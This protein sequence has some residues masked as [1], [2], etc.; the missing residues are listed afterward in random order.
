MAYWIHKAGTSTRPNY[1]FFYMDSDESVSELPTATTDGIKQSVDSSAHNVCSIGSKALSLSTSTIYK[2]DSNNKWV[3]QS[4]SS[5]S[6]SGGG[7]S[8]Y[9]I[10]VE[11]GFEG[12]VEEWLQSLN[13]KDGTDGTDGQTPTI[14]ENG[15]WFLGENDTGK[16][17]RGEKGEKG[18]SGE[19]G[20]AGA[21]GKDGKSA[22]EIAIE[23]GF[24]GT[25]KEWLASLEGMDGF[26][27]I[28]VENESNDDII[29]KLD[30]TTKT[31]TV[32]TPN[33]KGTDGVDGSVTPEQVQDAVEDYFEKNPIESLTPEEK[34][35][36]AS[37]ENKLDKNQG[38]EN[39]GKVLV[40]GGDGTV[41]PGETP[42]KVD[43]TLTQ[44]GQAADA[45]ATGDKLN[46]LSE[47]IGTTFS[48]ILKNNGISVIAEDGYY[49]TKGT[50]NPSATG[51]LF[52][53][54]PIFFVNN[55]P[56]IFV[57]YHSVVT[58]KGNKCNGQTFA[59]NIDSVPDFDK[60]AFNI[61]QDSVP[62]GEKIYLYL[63]YDLE[64]VKN[65]LEDVKN[66]L[67]DVKNNP[68]TTN[69]NSF[70]VGKKANFLGDSIT[71]GLWGGPEDDS[72][73]TIVDKKF[74]EVASE[75][76]GLDSI[77][78]GQ[79]GTCISSALD[80]SSQGAMSKRYKNMRDDADLIVVC[81]GTNDYGTN[82]PLGV[83][84]DTTDVS[85]YGGLKVLCN[86]LTEKY[87][88]KRI[89]FITPIHRGNEGNNSDGHT[90]I[91]YS[92][93][94]Y[95]VARDIFGFEVIDGFTLG[96]SPF[97]DEAKMYY[98]GHLDTLHPGPEGH[99]IYGTCLAHKLNVA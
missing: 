29:Y 19:K 20:P 7:Q 24:K 16:P 85:F 49:N 63:N 64:D 96:L 69:V 38:A 12:T 91:E 72:P 10:A 2:L 62:V 30:I 73:S 37:I 47:D 31:G 39:S 52:V 27:P 45:K 3:A 59:Q 9:Q 1:R 75:I 28:I 22:Y 33:L 65:D 98:F 17:S 40:V 90:L 76:L 94:I 46:S 78:Y 99:K 82:V 11:Y 34:E 88:G 41:T 79:S 74:W 21:N 14:G 87:L 23:N 93:A 25:E 35:Q 60:I 70:W 61:P 54:T 97:N 57:Q 77:G 13:G 44:S 83:I 95:D 68:P 80:P 56:K 86:G 4:S 5:G 48:G 58:W 43:P 26:S 66:D 36:I 89:V 50:I 84:G 18:D 8:A 6:S 15:N 42:I 55:V 71:V 51:S 92:K 53:H 67:E 81:G 32:T